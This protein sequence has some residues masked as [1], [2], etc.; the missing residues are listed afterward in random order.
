MTKSRLKLLPKPD[1]LEPEI[2]YSE[3]EVTALT[4]RTGN[5]S[6]LLGVLLGTT[7]SALIPKFSLD[8]KVLPIEELP[9]PFRN[10][11]LNND[12]RIDNLELYL[13]MREY[14]VNLRK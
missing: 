8:E 7:L 11:D 13:F 2:F 10:Y 3:K 9:S 6:L 12:G 1:I 5:Y 4:K 14:E